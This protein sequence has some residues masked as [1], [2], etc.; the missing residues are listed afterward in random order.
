MKKVTAVSFFF[1]MV[2]LLYA[3]TLDERN[4]TLNYE[5]INNN[6]SPQTESFGDVLL[7]E[8]KT[9]RLSFSNEEDED[10]N[11]CTVMGTNAPFSD[12]TVTCSESYATVLSANKGSTCEV[13]VTFTPTT[14][15]E[16]TGSFR[17]YCNDSSYNGNTRPSFYVGL[18]GNEAPANTA[19]TITSNGA[20]ATA[21]ISVEEN[22]I[23]VTTLTATDPQDDTVTFSISGGDDSSHFSLTDGVLTFSMAPDFENPGDNG[24]NNTYEVE[25]TAT[26]NGAG[27]LTDTQTITV[28]ITNVNESPI[29]VTEYSDITI[30]EDNGTT[31]FGIS[32]SDI[33]RAD[34]YLQ[35]DSN[36]TSILT[37]SQNWTNLISFDD[38]SST[39][40][41]FNLTTVQD[42]NGLVTISILLS[43][44][45][46]NTSTSFGIT[47]T[48][49][50]DAPAEDNSSTEDN[51]SVE[52]PVIHSID[53]NGTITKATYDDSLDVN[54]SQNETGIQSK[55]ET[56]ETTSLV[57]SSF[58]GNSTHL[59]YVEEKNSTTT[60]TSEIPGMHSYIDSDGNITSTI[61]N[62][63]ITYSVIA[64][65]DG[66]TSYMIKDSSGTVLSS[67]EL[68]FVGGTV[69]L[70]E[71]GNLIAYFEYDSFDG[72]DIQ[73]NRLRFTTTESS[74]LFSAFLNYGSIK[75]DIT[76]EINGTYI[77]L[78]GTSLKIDVE[79][80][81]GKVKSLTDILNGDNLTAVYHD[82]TKVLQSQNNSQLLINMSESGF[83]QIKETFEFGSKESTN[84]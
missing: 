7:G 64:H 39:T 37:V 79:T 73:L 76:Y 17:M 12:A 81:S 61:T 46:N 51:S 83:E 54:V 36:D 26:D 32:I 8:S 15:D 48:P 9:I 28:T 56:N 22:Q 4:V 63:E 13:D 57:T 42:A 43:D 65:N 11:N 84:E 72:E 16:A 1:L 80:Q 67:L 70:N 40:P 68:P 33:E 30:N 58:D 31:N 74:V 71:S 60:F 41:D 29:I 59:L 55:Y 6:Q 21:S 35:V 24:A 23:A 27:N 47:V 18:L 53:I 19:P 77:S 44:G 14:T 49:V 25:I 52:D 69:T 3:D 50:D 20:E 38:W 5:A 34:L 10:L 75:Q 82:D 45:E 66:S 78:E 2:S 62:N